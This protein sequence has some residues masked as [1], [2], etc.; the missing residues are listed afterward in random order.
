LYSDIYAVEMEAAAIAHTATMYKIPFIIYRSISD[1]L[2]DTS[3]NEDFNHFLE[4][5]SQNASKV[6]SELLLKF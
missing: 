5:A 3:Q 2:G 1:V 4:M 6:L